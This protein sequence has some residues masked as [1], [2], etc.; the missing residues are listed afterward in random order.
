MSDNSIEVIETKLDIL[1]ADFQAHRKGSVK[2]EEVV[3]IRGI[4]KMHSVIGG[5]L[6][7]IISAYLV[8]LIGA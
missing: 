1:I 7:V 8:H 4:L 6:F 2:E 5:F 3:E